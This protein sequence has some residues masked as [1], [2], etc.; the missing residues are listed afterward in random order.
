MNVVVGYNIADERDESTL[1]SSVPPRARLPGTR[2]G[3]VVHLSHT[4]QPLPL[5]YG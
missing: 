1:M 5:D 4:H 2:Q 3:S